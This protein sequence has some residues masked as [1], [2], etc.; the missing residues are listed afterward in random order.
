M[1]NG[2]IDFNEYFYSL[3]KPRTP[4]KKR[5][6]LRCQKVFLSDHYGNRICAQ[7]REIKVGMA[8]F[9]TP[10]GLMKGSAYRAV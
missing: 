9:Q 2:G 8:E 5:G 1:K 7:C 6:C 4:R 3:V 10:M